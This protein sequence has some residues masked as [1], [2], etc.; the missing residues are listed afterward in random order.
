[1]SMGTPLVLLI[2]RDMMLGAP[3][4]D[5]G[6]YL[7]YQE[8]ELPP[9]G[10]YN[11]PSPKKTAPRTKL[12]KDIITKAGTSATYAGIIAGVVGLGLIGVT[13]VVGSSVILT[14]VGTAAFGLGLLFGEVAA[15]SQ[16][17]QYGMGWDPS[18]ALMDI[19]AGIASL[20]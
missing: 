17:I 14:T 6:V 11:T 19:G 20:Y 7:E 16:S 1:M 13:A 15:I 9:T 2:R 12:S 4:M 3:G 8:L 5:L 18:A 10:S